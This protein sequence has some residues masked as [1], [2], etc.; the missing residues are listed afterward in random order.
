MRPSSWA[1]PVRVAAAVVVALGVLIAVISTSASAH[2]TAS[3]PTVIGPI[4]PTSGIEP[5]TLATTFPLSQVGYEESEYFISGKATAYSSG[6]PLTADG[7]W[8]VTPSSTAAY[9]TRVVVYRPI[10]PS[11]FNGTVMVEWLNVSGGLDDVPDWVLSHNE[12]I[13]DGF[14]WVGV[15]AQAVGVNA[16]VSSDPNRYGSLSDP[17]D[18]YSFD[19]FS[20]AGQAVWDNS[21]QLLGGLTPQHV[22]A[23][24]ESQ[25]ADRLVT[26]IDAVAPLV[27]VYDGYL[28]HSRIGTPAPLS[29]SPESAIAVPTSVQFRTDISAPVFEFETETDVAGTT[30]YDR[31]TNTNQFRLWEVA[32]A[33]TTTTTASSSGRLTPGTGRA[34][35]PTCRRCRTHRLRWRGWVPVPRRSTPAAPTGSW[36]P[37]SGGSTSGWS[38]APRRPFLRSW[39]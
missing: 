10:D 28:V 20:Q 39:T 12:L 25:S 9:E 15:S 2:G 32:G 8:S 31:Q 33:R 5:T 27:N 14:A 1:V 38:T 21:S 37:P 7:L 30:L 11:K 19:I 29:Q 18:S 16:L 23:M 36:R 6:N 34:P 3:D 24:G 17:G 22:L 4:L 13:R 35:S 26:Y